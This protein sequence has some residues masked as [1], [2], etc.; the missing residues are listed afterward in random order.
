MK[1][2]KVDSSIQEGKFKDADLKWFVV[3]RLIEDG[4]KEAGVC[5]IFL[6][7][8]LFLPATKSPLNNLVCAQHCC[9]YYNS[10][11]VGLVQVVQY[12]YF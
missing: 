7:G 8:A 10:T 2:K 1:D 4:N 9:L 6:L 11:R 12:I 5:S 3:C